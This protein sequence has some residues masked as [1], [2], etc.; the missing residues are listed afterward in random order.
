MNDSDL[1]IFLNNYNWEIV[2]NQI[3]KKFILKSFSTANKFYNMIAR[4][5]EVHN[6]H[7]RVII[8]YKQLEV[9]LTTHDFERITSKDINLGIKINDIFI[10]NYYEQD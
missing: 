10:E 3:Y 4:E 2:D 1:N 6:H 8:S 7:P 9:F 5:A